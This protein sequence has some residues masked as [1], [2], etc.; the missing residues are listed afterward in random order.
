[1]RGPLAIFLVTLVCGLS[2]CS[3]GEGDG[4]VD[5]ALFIRQC[6]KRTSVGA[7]G[8][9]MAYSYGEPGAPLAYNMQPSFFAAEPINDFTRLLPNNRLNIRVQ[10]DGSR[11]EQ[12][13]VLF[14]SIASV[15]PIATSLGQNVDV[16]PNTNVRATLSLN[17]SCPMPE[18]IPIL[19]GVINFAQFGDANNGHVAADFRLG[20][21][22]RLQAVFNFHVI[23]VRAATLGGTGNVPI[24]PAVGG[25][26]SG[27]FD[28]VVR[29]GQRAQSYP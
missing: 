5:G 16:G 26:I 1:M 2:A 10:S 9:A 3:L 14:I 22:D 23:D 18:V 21:A 29:Q 11:I 12:S 4:A 20:F 6:A 15:E 7:S 24:D 25:E 8:T 19:E 27:Y 28:F 13:D 17:Q